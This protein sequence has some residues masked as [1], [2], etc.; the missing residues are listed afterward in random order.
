MVYQHFTLVPSMTVA[1][2]LVLARADLP[3]VIDWRAERRGIDAFLARMPFSLDPDAPAAT[4]AAGEKQKLEILKQLYLGVRVLILDEPTSVLTPQ[5]SD[6]VLSHARRLADA[7]LL[8]V[9]LITHKFR[10]VRAHAGE[11]TV[12]RGGRNAGGGPVAALDTDALVE[13]TFGA[14]PAAGQRGTRRTRPGDAISSLRGMSALNDRGAPAVRDLSLQVAAGEIVGVAGVSGNG[15][16]ELVEVLAGQR[17]PEGGESM[18]AGQT[19]SPQ[20]GRDARARRV[21]SCRGAA[22]F[23]L[24]ALA[25]GGGQPRAARFRCAGFCAL[26]LVRRPRGD[27]RRARDLIG[28]FGIRCPGPARASIR[29]PA[30]TC[31]A[32]CWRASSRVKCGC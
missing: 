6:E 25:V 29:F 30:A 22:Q 21:P 28:R 4:L 12:L 2:N 3:A 8:T 17:E 13:M 9:V 15:Q 16:R 10:E 20:Q 14:R 5:E 32:R 27:Q 24:R 1:E 19:L 18:V 7:G 26:R 11:V 31:S 23:E